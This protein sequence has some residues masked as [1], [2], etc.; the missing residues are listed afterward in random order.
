MDII[1][2]DIQQCS[3]DIQQYSLAIQSKVN[4]HRADSSLIEESKRHKWT[5]LRAW[6][7][8]LSGPVEAIE[9]FFTA[10]FN[11]ILEDIPD[12]H[13]E[14]C[15]EISDAL[16][17]QPDSVTL[18]N[19]DIGIK[20]RVILLFCEK[21][22]DIVGQAID[23]GSF[24]RRM[25]F[26]R[27]LR[28]AVALGSMAPEACKALLTAGER[29][30][31]TEAE[32]F[33]EQLRL[34]HRRIDELCDSIR[35]F[36]PADDPGAVLSPAAA[37]GAARSRHL[38]AAAA[39]LLGDIEI[40]AETL[41]RDAAWLSERLV[42]KPTSPNAAPR[43]GPHPGRSEHGSRVPKLPNSEPDE[44]EAD[45]E[46]AEEVRRQLYETERRAALALDGAERVLDLLEDAA[47]RLDVAGAVRR[48]CLDAA[49][50]DARAG[51]P[52]RAPAGAPVPSHG[53][54]ESL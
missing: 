20:T 49:R 40:A 31:S 35:D 13:T 18:L 11:E 33:R 10:D 6:V 14:I 52:A 38:G 36:V 45:Q 28:E 21:G 2:R 3:L 32:Q 16:Q 15:H 4:L 22:A 43:G 37:S 8:S 12:L 53:V 34:A 48:G 30:T 42:R 50:R 26:G 41:S 5:G 46:E 44:T 29:L 17:I 39:V 23:A 27:F 25:P 51:G 1:L 47:L 24:L 7:E 19:I 54:A 9:L